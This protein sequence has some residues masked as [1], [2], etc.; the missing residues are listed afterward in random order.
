M[1]RTLI[2]S[3]LL[4]FSTTALVAAEAPADRWRFSV[5]ASDIAENREPWLGE[6]DDVRSGIGLA[7]AYAFAPQWDVELAVSSQSYRAPATHFEYLP[8]TNPALT[9]PV[10]TFRRYR[11]HP[12]DLVM[13]RH[14]LSESLFS[15]YVHAGVRYVD[16]PDDPAPSQPDVPAFNGA[17]PVREGFGLHD[18]TSAQAG[19]GV[20]IRLTPRT[21]LRAEVTRSLRSEETQFDPLTRGAIGVSWKF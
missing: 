21:A 1:P 14:F 12:V 16:A 2:A 15:P 7:L 11:V 13:T 3:L 20:R 5:L 17:R 8:G 19:A 9:V 6:Q 10:T 18:R 4:L